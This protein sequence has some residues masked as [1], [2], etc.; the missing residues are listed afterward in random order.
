MNANGD[1]LK[2]INFSFIIHS[3]LCKYSFSLDTFWTYLISMIGKAAATEGK[4]LRLKSVSSL[5]L[6]YT[7]FIICYHFQ[8]MVIMAVAENLFIPKA[9]KLNSQR[10]G[11]TISKG[12]KKIHKGNNHRIYFCK[13]KTVFAINQSL[14]IFMEK[15]FRKKLFCSHQKEFSLFIEWSRNIG[16]FFV[17]VFSHFIFYFCLRIDVILLVLYVKC[18]MTQVDFKGC[19]DLDSYSPYPLPDPAVRSKIYWILT[20]GAYC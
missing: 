12:K 1:I 18:Y 8:G 10:P 5:F 9:T 6:T 20:G 13:I 4:L 15:I 2:K 7:A 11:T 19:T 16:W 17:I 14:T 3:C